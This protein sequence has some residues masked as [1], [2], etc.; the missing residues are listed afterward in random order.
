MSHDYEK[1]IVVGYEILH[2][3]ENRIFLQ[4]CFS[5]VGHPQSLGV[6]INSWF[7]PVGEQT[8]IDMNDNAKRNGG[9]V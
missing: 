3:Q 8:T 2:S 7:K 1:I 5:I 9:L 6:Q 4:G